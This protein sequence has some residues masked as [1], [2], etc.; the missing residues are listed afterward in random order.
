MKRYRKKYKIK[1]KRE[2]EVE[3]DLEIV[4]GIGFGIGLGNFQPKK[5]YHSA[6]WHFTIL[7]F[8]FRFDIELSYF[9][10]NRKNKSHA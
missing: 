5:S 1:S 6:D 2:F 8:C 7:L 9:Y 10:K 3:L 4:P